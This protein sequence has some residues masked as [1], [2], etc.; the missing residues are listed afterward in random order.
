MTCIG[1][2]RGHAA[3]LWGYLKERVHQEDLDVNGKT[4]LKY[5]FKK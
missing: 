5:I 2:R 1:N 3:I 4:V